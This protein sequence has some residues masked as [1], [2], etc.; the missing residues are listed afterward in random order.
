MLIQDTRSLVV[1]LETSCWRS[2]WTANS[3]SWIASKVFLNLTRIVCDGLQRMTEQ[4][5]AVQMQNLL[6]LRM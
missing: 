5:V 3:R 6:R 2:R 1:L 4:H